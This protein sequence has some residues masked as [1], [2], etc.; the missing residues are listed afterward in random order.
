MSKRNW[1]ITKSCNIHCW[2]KVVTKFRW[3]IK[4]KTRGLLPTWEHKCGVV[5]TRHGWQG[6]TKGGG[7]IMRHGRQWAMQGLRLV[8][9]GRG[10][11]GRYGDGGDSGWCHCGAGRG[12]VLMAVAT[13]EGRQW[14][15]QGR[16]VLGLGG[17]RVGW[18]VGQCL[19]GGWG[20]SG[21][22]RW[23][24]RWV[25]GGSTRV[26]MWAGRACRHSC[27]IQN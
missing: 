25:A 3:Q 7:V 20:R 4:K 13:H 23:G 9:M 17:T 15:R 12:T 27:K 26:G 24:W 6:A 21:W 19:G 2:L 10:G 11:A 16:A 1:N 22:V 5:S 8:C 14:P 18:K